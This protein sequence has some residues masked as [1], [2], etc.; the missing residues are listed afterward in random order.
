MT[1]GPS[2]VLD[3][4]PLHEPPKSMKRFLAPR[5]MPSTVIWIGGL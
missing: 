4:H 5:H 2:E 1:R 3:A